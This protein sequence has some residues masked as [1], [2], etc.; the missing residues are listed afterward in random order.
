MRLERAASERAWD[1]LPHE[2]V[3]D[4]LFEE[5][6]ILAR[7]LA[8]RARS[9][10]DDAL[11]AISGHAARG[12]HAMAGYLVYLNHHAFFVGRGGEQLPLVRD[13]DVAADK[14]RAELRAL[15]R[16]RVV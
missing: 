13:V 5:A 15:Q 9:S 1:D 7:L 10:T 8:R 3:G 16:Q 14:I 6:R 11:A 4:L 12:D 2:H